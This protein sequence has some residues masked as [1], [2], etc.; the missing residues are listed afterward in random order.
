MNDDDSRGPVAR[1]IHCPK[2]PHHEIC[3]SGC[4]YQKSDQPT[5]KS[6]LGRGKHLIHLV[7]EGRLGGDINTHQILRL[8]QTD[9][10][11][12]TNNLDRFDHIALP[13]RLNR[14]FGK[15]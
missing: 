2:S 3:N 10:P 9:T 1:L 7:L 5:D 11:L 6:L 4:E 15:I 8:F 13:Q 12:L 14:R